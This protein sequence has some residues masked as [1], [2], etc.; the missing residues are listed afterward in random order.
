MSWDFYTNKQV[1]A[2]KDY[3]CDWQEHLSLCDIINV[4][5]KAIPDTVNYEQ[6]KEIG[7][8]DDEIKTIEQYIADGYIIKKGE[9]HNVTSGKIEGMFAEFRCKVAISDIIHKYDLASED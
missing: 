2:R 6:A 1:K 7:L 9:L 4:G 8:N 5:S 3:R